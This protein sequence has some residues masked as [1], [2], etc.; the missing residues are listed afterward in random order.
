MTTATGG[1]KIRHIVTAVAAVAILYFGMQVYGG[2][3]R[4]PRDIT[5]SV[6]VAASGRVTHVNWRI[7]SKGG[8]P[9]FAGHD[10]THDVTLP[11]SGTYTLTLQAVVAPI[12]A[13]DAHG[14][15][16]FRGATATCKII[17]AGSTSSNVGPS[18]AGKG[19]SLTKIYVVPPDR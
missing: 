18:S 4:D 11:K 3:Q 16:I 6:N 17:V 5:F 19:C 1:L 8:D 9:S 14:G 2:F 12:R 13:T 15:T 10:W 7:D